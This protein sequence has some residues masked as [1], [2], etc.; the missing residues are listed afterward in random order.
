MNGSQPPYV[1]KDSHDSI[2]HVLHFKIVDLLSNLQKCDPALLEDRDK[3]VQRCTTMANTVLNSV[4]LAERGKAF[5]ARSVFREG[6]EEFGQLPTIDTS[7]PT[8]DP[9][10]LPDY[11]YRMKS[12][13]KRPSSKDDLFHIP[14]NMRHKAGPQRFSTSGVPCLYLAGST[15][16]CW[17]EMD[18]PPF[19]QAYVSLFTSRKD[20][21]RCVDL[22]PTIHLVQML[23]ERNASDSRIK[24]IAQKAIELFPLILAC[25]IKRR[26]D[27][28]KFNPEYLI[29]QM[30]LEWVI[31]DDD[32]NG[33]S[34]NST[35]FLMQSPS[36]IPYLANYVFPAEIPQHQNPY[37]GVRSPNLEHLFE[38]SSPVH[39]QG[40]LATT[41]WKGPYEYHHAIPNGTGSETMNYDTEFGKVEGQLRA[42]FSKTKP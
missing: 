28:A 5:E 24:Q 10:H 3:A 30:L 21:I 29:P 31:E 23:Q 9:S 11:F 42:S 2:H 39:W 19:H 17:Q 40:V 38:Q 41:Q 12:G 6:M 27:G 35:R 22:R 8:D 25:S 16:T 18:C 36:G 15:F 14:I 1:W 4:T 13:S 20:E 33:V 7:L 32:L 34:Y 26:Y 37:L